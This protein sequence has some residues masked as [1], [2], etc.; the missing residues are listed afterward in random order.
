[1]VTVRCTESANFTPE[2]GGA[3]RYWIFDNNNQGVLER[4]EIT[5]TS[6][7]DA[8]Q[9]A[10]D[11]LEAIDD[12]N[13]GPISVDMETLLQ[14]L[15]MSW[16]LKTAARRNNPSLVNNKRATLNVDEGSGNPLKFTTG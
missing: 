5:G 14:N 3:G 11:M 12:P 2:G 16:S 13:R 8:L 9:N 4:R 1:M 6:A 15:L 7:A 10:R